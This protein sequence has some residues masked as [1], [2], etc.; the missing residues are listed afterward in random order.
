MS[1]HNPQFL[2][3]LVVALVPL[4]V[5]VYARWFGDDIARRAVQMLN[6][7]RVRR[8]KRA[9]EPWLLVV[10]WTLVLVLIVVALAGPVVRTPLFPR[11][12]PPGSRTTIVLLDCSK[13]ME[14]KG[15]ESSKAWAQGFFNEMQPD[16][17]VAVYGVIDGELVPLLAP[18][19]ANPTF[20]RSSIVLLPQLR[21]TADWPVSVD[22]AMRLLAG[23]PG[24]GDILVLTDDGRR[25]EEQ[26]AQ[27]GRG[28]A[29]GQ[30]LPRVWVVGTASVRS[31]GLDQSVNERSRVETVSSLEELRERRGRGPASRGVGGMVM[32]IALALVGL[33]LAYIRWSRRST[34]P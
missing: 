12:E 1:F 22:A 31:K 9:I 6:V 13:S 2:F 24:E 30:E 33:Q 7:S 23:T 26:I 29:E 4:A 19:S 25:V 28:V 15:M 3:A 32:L 16:D 5:R 18:P 34:R 14:G 17:R 20:A 8:W 11:H 21:G 10:G 27:G